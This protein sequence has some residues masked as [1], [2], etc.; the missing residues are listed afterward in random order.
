MADGGPPVPQPP[1]VPQAP[2]VVHAAPPTQPAIPPAQPGQVPQLHWSHVKPELAEKLDKDAEVH[3]LGTNDW[4]DTHAFQ[5]GAKVQRFCLTL[6]GEARL[7]YES[8]RSIAVDWNGLDAQFRQQYLRIDNMRE[9][10]FHVWR[11]FHFDKNSENMD[12]YILH[13]RW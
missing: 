2:P 13:I 12:S 6:V 8:L 4:M 5:E 10:L 7:W 9:K 3:L 1:T 11:T